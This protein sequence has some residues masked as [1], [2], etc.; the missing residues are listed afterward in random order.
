MK[1][2]FILISLLVLVSCSFDD[3]TGIW[4]NK[5]TTTKEGKENNDVFKEFEKIILTETTF[6]KEIPFKNNFVFNVPK[7]K[8]NS[9]W[10]D[11][12]YSL[13]N[14]LENFKYDDLN[15]LSLKSRKLTNNNTNK[16]KLFKNEYLIISDSKGNIILFSI[17]SKKIISKFNFYKKRFKKIKKKLNLIIIDEIIFAAD[18]L[19]YIYAYDYKNN[20]IIW[21]KNYKVPF[22]SNLKVFKDK[23]IVSNV[24]NNLLI[25]NKRNGD[26][27][28]LIPTE[29][30]SVKNNFSN[31]ISINSENELFFLNSFG[32]LYKININSL[33]IIWFNNFNKSLDTNSSNL[34]FGS[35]IISTKKEVIFSS[36]K[37]TYIVDVISGSVL[38]KYNF[39]SKVKPIIIDKAAIFLTKNNFLIAINLN[40]KK[41][42]YSYNLDTLDNYLKNKY[43]IMDM[44]LLNNE[45]FI[46]L[47]NNKIL[48]F[49]INGK[50]KTL[51]KLPSSLNTFPIS[52]NNS[53]LYLN[54]SNQLIILN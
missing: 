28:K 44:M 41:I 1:I 20:K 4:K 38:K 2:F 18:N 48:V 16:F 35:N 37:S 27:I 51:K 23:I 42:I 17:Y 25:L 13:N 15:F 24:N 36:N 29:E 7:A 52:I 31:K 19:G 30:I 47:K 46:F 9:K 49:Q 26:L 50:F 11:I 40:T 32:S 34:F 6:N 10:D 22:S 8:T 21:A 45:I 53:I 5:N 33:S 54:N 12:F 39:S 43:F 14:N 3:K